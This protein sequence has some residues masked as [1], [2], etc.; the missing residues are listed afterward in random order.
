MA[1]FVL[2]HGAFAGGWYLRPVAQR[3]R[4]AGHEAYTPTLTGLGERVHLASSAVGLE[5]HVA[6]VANVLV[7][8]D[9]RDVVLVGKSLAGV[10][11]TGVA[12]RVPERLAHLVYLDALVPRDGEAALDLVDPATVAGLEVA[13]RASGDGWRVPVNP[14]AADARLTP[15]PLRPTQERLVLRN[16]AAAAL[17]RTYIAATQRGEA[18]LMAAVALGAHRAREAGWAYHEVPTGHEPERDAPDAVAA[19]L[20]ALA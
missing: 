13:A 16:P 11:V 3:L 15:H 5:T 14:N 17:P 6:D 20:L 7:Y 18:G 10:V 1:T 9:L 19:L 4:A 2:V 12:E 8:E